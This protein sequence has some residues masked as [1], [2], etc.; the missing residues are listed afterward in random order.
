[1]TI[2]STDILKIALIPGNAESLH[3]EVSGNMLLSGMVNNVKRIRNAMFV[4]VAATT[5]F[6]VTSALTDGGY[7]LASATLATASAGITALVAKNLYK[8][9]SMVVGFVNMAVA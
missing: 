8:T 1:M 5:A 4:G 6:A 9:T 2:S 7:S 3:N